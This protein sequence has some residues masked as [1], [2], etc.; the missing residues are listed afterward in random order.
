MGFS[1]GPTIVTSGLVLAWDIAD[2]N[3]YPGTGTTVFDMSGNG[4]NGTITGGV[5]YNAATV[6]GVLT[7]NGTTGYISSATP[8]L[9]AT[10]YTVIGAA[11][12]NGATR[13]RMINSTANNWLLGHW[14]GAGTPGVANYY[15]EGWITSAVSSQGGSDT[16]WRIYAGTGNIAGDS[17][18]FYINN[19]LNAGPNTN[20]SAGPNGITI[21]RYAPG[22]NEYSTGDF[23]FVLVYNRILT[24]DEI[25]QNYNA[26]KSRFGL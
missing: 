2:R 9:A 24:T 3:S 18:A 13:Q 20:G 25:A 6:S 26:Q 14:G 1:D 12:Y 11:R 15:A 7:T 23:S 8:N 10:S 21:G 17:Y 16:T 4:N 19:T 5:T 22:N